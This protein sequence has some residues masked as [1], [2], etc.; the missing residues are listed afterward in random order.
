VL[1]LRRHVRVHLLVPPVLLDVAA[2]IDF[3]SE[4]GAKLKAINHIFVSKR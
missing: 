1:H 3:E 4:I 2:Q